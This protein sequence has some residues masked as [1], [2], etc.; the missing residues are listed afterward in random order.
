MRDLVLQV[1]GHEV[2]LEG[3]ETRRW[4]EATE[5][6][7]ARLLV[8]GDNLL[9]AE[10]RNPYGVG[11]L[12]LR[13]DGP[14]EPLVTDEHW[15]AAW[16]GDA[17]APAAIADDGA[18]LPDSTALPSPMAGIRQHAVA[19]LVLFG[20]GIVSFL[21]VRGRPEARALAPRAAL[22]LVVVFWAWLFLGKIIRIPADAGFDA[23]AHLAYIGWLLHQGTLPLANQGLQTYQP[24]LYH[25]ATALLL[26][27]VPA[28]QNSAAQRAVLSLLPFLSG[29]GMV[30][31]SAAMAKLLL[32]DSPWIQ[33]GAILCAGFLPMNL[34]L[35]AYVSNEAPHAFLASLAV[36]ATLRALLAKSTT[37]QDDWAL[38]LFLGLA[39]LTKYTSAVLVPV[40]AGAV[41]LKRWIAESEPPRTIAAGAA[42]S[43]GAVAGLA[44]W[45]YLR[46]FL[47]FGDPFIWTLDAWPGK[48]LWQFPD[49]HTVGYF[50]RFG[51]ALTQ[52]WFSGFHGFWD[53]VYTT[54]WGDGMLAGAA[55]V[56]YFHG[57]WRCDWMAAAFLLALPATVCV[58]LG[59]I[60]AGRE[61]LRGSDLG[62]RLAFSLLVGLPP[63]L[64]LSLVNINLLYPFWSFPK[65]FYA[66]FLTPTFAL[67]GALG[68]DSVDRV[69]ARRAW[70]ALRTLP[71]GWAAAFL[72][73]VAIAYGG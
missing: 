39:L 34:T 14:V 1:N 27:L 44:G 5:V 33:A 58:V 9:R 49:F 37:R 54:F 24:P 25:A 31:V 16:E 68:F 19:L 40:L 67:L 4:K 12:Q 2:A 64:L 38:G 11:L 8:T 56:E 72:G 70:T 69:L 45:F 36:L 20:V 3:R 30:F 71:W 59:W 51:D 41:A 42:R 52:P 28:A 15:Q 13:V 53:A 6:D 50:L 43:L 29:L 35:A 63:L 46:N 17:L 22:A 7:V 62:R 32:A 21:G 10:V 61:A 66:L 48:A 26:T 18:R 65:A 23:P 55:G 47:Y 57:R 60:R 73:S